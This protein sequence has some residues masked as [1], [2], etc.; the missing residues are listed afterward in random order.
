MPNSGPSTIPAG[1]SNVIGPSLG[2]ALPPVSGGPPPVSADKYSALAELESAFSAP[3][4][5]TTASVVNWNSSWVSRNSTQPNWVESATT[6]TSKSAQQ[7]SWAESATTGSVFGSSGGHL[8]SSGFIYGVG[9]V[10]NA[11]STTGF[12]ASAGLT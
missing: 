3:T 8:G 6:G 10:P 12:P 4:V 1:A 9:V 11:A 7:P 2:G 5:T